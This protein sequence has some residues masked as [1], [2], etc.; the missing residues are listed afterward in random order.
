MRLKQLVGARILEVCQP[1]TIDNLAFAALPLANE[2]LPN[3]YETLILFSLT[4]SNAGRDG[5]WYSLSPC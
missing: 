4:Y 1:N 2:L 3:S 5:Y